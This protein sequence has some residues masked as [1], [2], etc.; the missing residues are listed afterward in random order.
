MKIKTILNSLVLISFILTFQMLNFSRYILSSFETEFHENEKGLSLYII[1]IGVNWC[2]FQSD[3]ECNLKYHLNSV[4]NWVHDLLSNK[5]MH[6]YHWHE[7]NILKRTGNLHYINP[8]IDLHS[9]HT[10]LVANLFGDDW[11]WL[12]VSWRAP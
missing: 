10:Y 2:N 1:L 11:Q 12:L 3:T 5:F 6:H 7:P 9:N 4:I 8:Y